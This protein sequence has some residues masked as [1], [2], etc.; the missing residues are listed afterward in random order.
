[1][2]AVVSHTID[3]A[4]MH[5]FEREPPA[6][7][8]CVVDALSMMAGQPLFEQRHGRDIAFSAIYSVI[9]YCRGLSGV[10]VYLSF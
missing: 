3:E 9:C 4:G 7:Y 2:G 5:L 10:V 6:Y 8:G 1:M